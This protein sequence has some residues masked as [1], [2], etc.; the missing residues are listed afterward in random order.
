MSKEEIDQ[1]YP[2]PEASDTRCWG[3]TPSAKDREIIGAQIGGA[4]CTSPGEIGA[5][6]AR[7]ERWI[8]RG[9]V[10]LMARADLGPRWGELAKM[11]TLFIIKPDGSLAAPENYERKP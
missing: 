10:E 11:P 3:L 7:V 8:D 9:V 1:D 6:I 4:I 5:G 2:P